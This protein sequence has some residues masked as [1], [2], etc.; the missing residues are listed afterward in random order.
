MGVF[1]FVGVYVISVCIKPTVKRLKERIIHDNLY[2][3]MKHRDN[4]QL[5]LLQGMSV[6]V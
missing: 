1:V 4:L 5:S 6:N 2:P 3:A